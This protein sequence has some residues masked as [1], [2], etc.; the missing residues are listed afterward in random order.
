MVYDCQGKHNG[1]SKR[2]SRK[3]EVR[4]KLRTWRAAALI[5]PASS[6]MTEMIAGGIC[7]LPSGVST[8]VV[9][10]YM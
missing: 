5:G 10:A 4:K 1:P 9:L 2:Y 7:S 8:L 6:R 3:L